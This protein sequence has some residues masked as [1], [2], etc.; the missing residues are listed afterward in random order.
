MFFFLFCRFG[1][2]FLECTSFVCS[3]GV[4]PPVPLTEKEYLFESVLR[5]APHLHLL[6]ISSALLFFSGFVAKH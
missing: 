6:F 5:E 1:I 3:H 4:Y 2:F